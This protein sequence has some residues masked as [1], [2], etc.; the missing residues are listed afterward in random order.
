M[1]GAATRL[2]TFDGIGDISCSHLTA[3][4]GRYQGICLVPLRVH[5]QLTRSSDECELALEWLK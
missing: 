4:D 2:G 3:R 1:A 5:A